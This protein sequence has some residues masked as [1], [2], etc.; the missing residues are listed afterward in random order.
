M[1]MT[2]FVRSTAAL[3][4]FTAGHVMAQP[5]ASEHWEAGKNYFLIEPAQATQTGDKIEV[6]EVF[7]WGCPACNASYPFVDDL[8][9]A[10]PANAQMNYV[11]ASFHPEE[12]WVLFQRAFFAAKALGVEEKAHD[13][14]FDAIWKTGE[15]AT[16]ANGRPKQNLP[17][18]QDVAKFFAKYG[19]QPKTFV[20]TANSFAVNTK[21]RQA[22]AYVKATGVDQTPTI[23]VNGKYRLTTISAGGGWDKAKALVLYLVRKESSGG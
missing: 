23:I 11:P 16:Y 3:A 15:L 21:M 14:M 2:R 1:R 8:K 12:D 5:A 19:V 10:L 18:L 17:T 7:S 4:L 6:T 20:A 13:A 22:D 9:K